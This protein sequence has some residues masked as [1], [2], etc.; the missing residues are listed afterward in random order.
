VDYEQLLFICKT[1]HEYKNFSKRILK[2]HVDLS[3]GEVNKQWKK[4][5]KKRKAIKQ[6]PQTEKALAHERAPSNPNSKEALASSFV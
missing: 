5:R 4:P 6:S 2:D 1:C 3:V